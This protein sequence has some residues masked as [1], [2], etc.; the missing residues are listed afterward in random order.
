M[1]VLAVVWVVE[2]M[3]NIG[4]GELVG[5]FVFIYPVVVC[6]VV[7]YLWLIILVIVYSVVLTFYPL[8]FFQQLLGWWKLLQL[9]HRPIQCIQRERSWLKL[10]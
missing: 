7:V 10:L 4:L 5:V 8:S 1:A 2:K 9:Q 3:D 6:P